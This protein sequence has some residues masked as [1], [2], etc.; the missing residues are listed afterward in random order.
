MKE[1]KWNL[2]KF[3]T[4]NAFT[5]LREIF[6]FKIIFFLINNCDFLSHNS[7]FFL[8]ILHLS[9]T[10][11]T[12]PLIILRIKLHLI[13]RIVRSIDLSIDIY[14]SIYLDI[15]LDIFFK[16]SQLWQA[17]IFKFVLKTLLF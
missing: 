2:L 1:G 13:L 17:N 5:V 15:Y 9:F 12:F 6:F 16:L 14:L 4:A 8:A 10:I 11:L 7:D 3:N